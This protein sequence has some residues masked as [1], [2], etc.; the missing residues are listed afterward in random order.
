MTWHDRHVR[1]FYAVENNLVLSALRLTMAFSN[2]IARRG[3]FITMSYTSDIGQVITLVVSKA[4]AC[5]ERQGRSMDVMFFLCKL[6][7]PSS[8]NL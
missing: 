3:C 4:V 8:R 5:W 2:A 7:I 6:G 1:K